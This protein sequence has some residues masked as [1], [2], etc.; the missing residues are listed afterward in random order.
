MKNLTLRSLLMIGFGL[1]IGL[2]ALIGG[3]S[4]YSTNNL[5]SSITDIVHRRIPNLTNYGT[6]ETE[7]YVLR[8]AALSVFKEDTATSNS[9]N[10]L[11]EVINIRKQTWMRL[12][13]TMKQIDSVPRVTQA[14]KDQYSK[15]LASLDEYRK[16]NAPLDYTLPKLTAAA[17]SRDE[18]QFKSARDEYRG[19]YE[20]VLDSS[21]QLREMVADYAQ[22][23]VSLGMSD[24]EAASAH[25]HMYSTLTTVLVIAG[26]LCGILIGSMILRAVI[27]QIG[28]EPGYIQSIMQHVSN[29]DLSVKVN[30]RPGDTSS[31]LH[32]ISVTISKLREIIDIIS[33]SANEI[34]S[35]SEEL[36]ATSDKIAASSESQSQ[37]ATSMAASIEQMTV[38]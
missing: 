26:I 16:V 30:L 25:S 31:T 34:A 10:N 18:E 12:D 3:L 5:A 28:G 29:A 8:S 33:S 1:L 2:L 6:L 4:I 27:R 13:E 14:T 24:G 21:K 15:L 38:S 9:A 35:T 11:N 20:K 23:Q 22:N 7:I 17:A 37:A 32:A 19:I 36:S